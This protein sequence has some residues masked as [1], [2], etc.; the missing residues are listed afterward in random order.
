M[1]LLVSIDG[2]V[3][4]VH[5][6]RAAN[7]ASLTSIK[8]PETTIGKFLDENSDILLSALNAIKIIPQPKLEWIKKIS[9]NNKSTIIPD[10][11]FV[12]HQG[13]AHL[14]DLKLPLL[15]KKS[16][17]KGDRERRRFI[18]NVAEGISQLANYEEYFTY[19]E[20]ANYAL[21]KYGITMNKPRKVLIVGSFENFNA[22]KVSEAN[23][24]RGANAPEIIDYDTLRNAYLMNKGVL[25]H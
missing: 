16:L 22:D 24:E 7:F 5:L 14:C 2:D 13:N 20:N 9:G 8:T 10:F 25:S 23:R 21:K 1:H 11:I 6:N 18:D 4:G 19:P 15:D 17:T 12:D 3:N